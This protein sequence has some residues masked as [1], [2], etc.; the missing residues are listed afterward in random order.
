MN[1]PKFNKSE[2]KVLREFEELGEHRNGRLSAQSGADRQRRF[3]AFLSLEK[4][5]VVRIVQR[6]PFR[7]LS[8]RRRI[9][10]DYEWVSGVYLIAELIA[11][12]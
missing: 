2:T 10:G 5:G 11:S 7:F 1:M 9:T 4:K 6:E 12:E 3:K 8:N